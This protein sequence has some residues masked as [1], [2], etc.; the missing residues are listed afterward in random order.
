M[1]QVTCKSALLEY[2]DGDL[3]ILCLNENE[4]KSVLRSFIFMLGDKSTPET[5]LHFYVYFIKYIHSQD[6]TN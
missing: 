2:L 6:W 4:K 5:P 1:Q 3:C